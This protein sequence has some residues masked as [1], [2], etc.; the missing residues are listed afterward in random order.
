MD[1]L[2]DKNSSE[3]NGIVQPAKLKI[4]Y[5]ALRGRAQVPRLLLEYLKVPYEDELFMSKAEWMT[6]RQ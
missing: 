6:Y 2:S 3:T 1:S 5:Y 4:G